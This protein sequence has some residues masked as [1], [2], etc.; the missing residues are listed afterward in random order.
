MVF[1]LLSEK[2]SLREWL[3]RDHLFVIHYREE[4][5]KILSGYDYV[6]Y[7]LTYT[8]PHPRIEKTYFSSLPRVAFTSGLSCF[9]SPRRLLRGNAYFLHDSDNEYRKDRTRE[10]IHF[11]SL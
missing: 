9:L 1:T 11:T 6:V 10:G 7:A 4:D 5:Q 3:T 2:A 8:I